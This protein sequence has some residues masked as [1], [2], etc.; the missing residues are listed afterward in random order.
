MTL[1]AGAFAYDSAAALEPSNLRVWRAFFEPLAASGVLHQLETKDLVV[2]KWDS[3]AHA[4]PAW[5]APGD[6]SLWT[7]V[8]D[9]LLQHQGR[10]LVR[11][12][13]LDRMRGARGGLDTVAL[14]QARGVFAIVG[15][16]AARSELT[17]ATDLIGV[18]PLY[19]SC[20]DGVI[21]FASALHL[22][23][24]LPRLRRR[25]DDEGLAEHLA[26]SFCLADRTP[27]RDIALLPECTVLRIGRSGVVRSSYFDWS[28]LTVTPEAPEDCAARLFRSFDEAV[29]LR[30]DGHKSAA[31][32]LSGGMDSRAIVAGLLAQ[33]CDIQ[34]LNFSPD[35]T[36]DQ[37]FAVDYARS[38]GERCNLSL[39]PRPDNP[40]FSL[41][42]AQALQAQ[43]AREQGVAPP[44]DRCLWSG[45]GGS[46]CLGYV[47]LDDDTMRLA[48]EGAWH[49]AAHLF[50]SKNKI[51][52]PDRLFASP[53]RET[54]NAQLAK[55]VQA[56]MQR[57]DNGDPGR[58]L[59]FFLLFNDQR[60][61]LHK[62]FETI[63][64]HGLE[65]HL[66]FFDTAFVRD[67]V[68]TPAVWGLAH[69]LYNRWFSHFEEEARATPWQTYPGHEPCP[70]APKQ[71]G[72]YQWAPEL[73]VDKRLDW[74]GRRADSLALIRSARAP[75]SRSRLSLLAVGSA[76]VLHAA[77]LRNLH[78]LATAARRLNALR[79]T[80]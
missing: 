79:W 80:E 1:I 18:R 43:A 44:H 21:Y 12:E 28:T 59:Y 19:Y 17:I 14:A 64:Q 42:A 41:L 33:G 11:S 46:V 26:F 45:D 27:Y 2:F 57:Y 24:A 37:V 25:L 77:R 15:F 58:G 76:S 68:R 67:V 63:H 50:L 56:E 66:P 60:R 4:E 35:H 75:V 7:L 69:R 29:R 49:E 30:L 55:R 40:N 31:A 39:H 71:N 10:R 8:G 53:W 51:R 78:H 52:V 38:V 32:F 54:S 34:A 36:Q 22:L 13:Q 3:E 70:I 73:R 16:D 23:E 74:A 65:F 62:H 6:G 47:Y 20:Q 72:V 5:S 61:H 9:P 48:R